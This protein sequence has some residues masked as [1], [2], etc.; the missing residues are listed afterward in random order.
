MRAALV[1]RLLASPRTFTGLGWQRGWNL[2]HP[3]LGGQLAPVLTALADPGAPQPDPDQAYLALMLARQASPADV[4]TSVLE[5]A[6]RPDLDHGLRAVAARTAATLDE[7]AAV[8]V[9]AGVLAE[10]SEHPDHDPD[11]ELRGIAL[12]VLWPGHLAADVLAAS[13][14]TPRRDNILGAYYMFR[15]RL[16]A[17]CLTTTFP[18]LLNRALTARPGPACSGRGPGRGRLAVTGRRRPG[19]RPTGPGLR[20]QRP[21]AVIGPAAALAAR[22]CKT[23]GTC[24]PRGA[25]RPRCRRDPD[26][27]SARAAPAPGRPPAQRPGRRAWRLPADLGLAAVAGSAGTGHGSGPPRRAPLPGVTA[28]L[29]AGRRTC[30]GRWRRR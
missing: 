18:D 12:S 11:D 23:A 13:L 10:I 16:P 1:E 22:C 15:R 30:A 4:I 14:T 29:A 19:G 17:S 7:A 3:G 8:P 2:T 25:R 20:P 21:D 24:H 27:R 28:G 9:L 6:D 5:A 26:R